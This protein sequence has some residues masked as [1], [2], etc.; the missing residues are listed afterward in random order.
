MGLI[1]IGAACSVALAGFGGSFGQGYVGSKAVE[2]IA[3]QPEATEKIRTL[4]FISLAFI[5][6]LTI[7]GLLVAFMLVTKI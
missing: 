2:G 4:L 5:E 1:A 3:R 7:Y 6:T